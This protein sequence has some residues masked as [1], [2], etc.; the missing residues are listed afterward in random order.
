MI[1]THREE[2]K[3]EPFWVCDPL[4]RLEY[5]IILDASLTSDSYVLRDESTVLGFN[6]I[7]KPSCRPCSKYGFL[8]LF[9]TPV[10]STTAKPTTE[11][12]EIPTKELPNI[13]QVFVQI[14]RGTALTGLAAQ[15]LAKRR[16]GGSCT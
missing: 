2:S 6:D 16:R 8:F 7:L 14:C 10:L 5:E 9:T 4:F 3:S 1:P 13:L 11:A 12:T 15:A